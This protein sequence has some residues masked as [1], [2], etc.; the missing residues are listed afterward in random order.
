MGRKQTKQHREDALRVLKRGT[1]VLDKF[2]AVF[3]AAGITC[4]DDVDLLCLG[5]SPEEPSCLWRPSPRRNKS[6]TVAS[7][8]A[9]ASEGGTGS[10]LPPSYS[11]GRSASWLW[12]W[13]TS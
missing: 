12:G 1:A 3:G 13:R 4:G 9:A 10:S 2:E 7:V 11:A 5:T 8:S 6:P